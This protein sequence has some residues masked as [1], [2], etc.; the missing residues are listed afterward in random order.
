MIE[1]LLKHGSEYVIVI[2]RGTDVQFGNTAFGAQMASI[3]GLNFSK[4]GVIKE[5]PDLKDDEEWKLKAI[6]RFKQ[7]IK[8]MKNEE[9]ISEYI[10]NDLKNHGYLPMKIKKEGFRAKKIKNV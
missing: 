8:K 2:I 3:D 10:M 5:F 1:L 4:Q 9:E 7:N 6:D